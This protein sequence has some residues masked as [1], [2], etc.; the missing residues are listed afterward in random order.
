MLVLTRFWVIDDWGEEFFIIIK[1]GV[2]ILLPTGNTVDSKVLDEQVATNEDLQTLNQIEEDDDE[3]IE[4][5]L[6]PNKGSNGA[7][8]NRN[9]S[10]NPLN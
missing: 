2:F 9:S 5:P 10:M 4:S 7:E 6:L 3:S 1:G 8:T